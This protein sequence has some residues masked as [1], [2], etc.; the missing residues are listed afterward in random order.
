[1]YMNGIVHYTKCSFLSYYVVRVLNNRLKDTNLSYC[2]R[3]WTSSFPSNF[4]LFQNIFI[5]YSFSP[6]LSFFSHFKKNIN[7]VERCSVFFQTC[8]P[9]F[10]NKWKRPEISLFFWQWFFRCAWIVDRFKCCVGFS[11]A[12]R[13][14]GSS[15]IFGDVPELRASFPVGWRTTPG[16]APRHD[17]QDRRIGVA[18]GQT[19]PYRRRRQRRCKIFSH[20]KFCRLVHFL[21]I[22]TENE[23]QTNRILL[24]VVMKL[25]KW[26]NLLN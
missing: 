12:G 5:L 14:A 2:N 15:V 21:E 9:F 1:M 4:K 16:I 6:I 11:F 10:E 3:T 7:F 18:P 19:G 13:Q 26:S 8:E 17:V 24:Y 23:S 25:Y 20:S 22:S